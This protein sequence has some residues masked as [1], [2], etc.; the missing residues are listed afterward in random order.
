[1][2][3]LV[4]IGPTRKKNKI[5]RQNTFLCGGSRYRWGNLAHNGSKDLRQRKPRRHLALPPSMFHSHDRAETTR[6]GV[7]GFVALW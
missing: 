2:P 3:T 5:N 7:K 1:M 6:L 4:V